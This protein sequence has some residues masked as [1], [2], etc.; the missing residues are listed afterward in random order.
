MDSHDVGDVV[1]MRKDHGLEE[2]VTPFRRHHIAARSVLTGTA[3]EGRGGVEGTPD[4]ALFI[5]Q[6]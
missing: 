1:S 6:R 2:H 3:A 4:A 5:W